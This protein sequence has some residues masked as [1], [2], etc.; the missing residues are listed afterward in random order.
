MWWWHSIKAW[1]S[2]RWRPQPKPKQELTRE[3]AALLFVGV[4]ILTTLAI[5]LLLS[6][7]GNLN[8][9]SPISVVNKKKE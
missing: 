4:Y 8:A 2:A 1:W 7:A 5:M 9:S 6:P 3:E